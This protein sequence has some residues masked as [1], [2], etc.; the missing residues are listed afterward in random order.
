MHTAL[1]LAG[2]SLATSTA[3]AQQPKGTN[4]NSDAKMVADF[5]ARVADYVKLRNAQTQ[6]APP[7][8]KDAT[9]EELSAA[10]KALATKVAAARANAKRGDIFTP[11]TQAMFRRLLNPVVKGPEGGEV[12]E[13]M[14][15]DAPAPSELPYKI[16]AQYPKNV[17]L[18]TVPSDVL[19]TLPKLPEDIQYRFAGKTLMLYDIKPNLIVDFMPNALP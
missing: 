3:A 17:P 14:K 15:E 11:A 18:S 4:V 2:F 7:M 9:P 5:T 10:E 12:K 1:W 8:K 16:N 6:G 19:L 13:A